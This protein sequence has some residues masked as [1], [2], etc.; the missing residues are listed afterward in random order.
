M[1]LRLWNATAN[2]EKV[3]SAFDYAPKTD[4]DWCRLQR[5]QIR[6]HLALLMESGASLAQVAPFVMAQYGGPEG[7]QRLKVIF[8]GLADNV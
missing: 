1:S 7:L 5:A 6:L 8:G 2:M 3:A 4:Q